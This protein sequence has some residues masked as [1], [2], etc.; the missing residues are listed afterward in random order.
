[1][2]HARD[3]QLRLL[4]VPADANILFLRSRE[5]DVNDEVLRRV[6]YVYLRLE[7]FST[8]SLIT[9]LV[10]AE[11]LRLEDVGDGTEWSGVRMELAAA[12]VSSPAAA[13]SSAVS[14]SRTSSVPR[15]RS[16]VVVMMFM[17]TRGKTTRL[18]RSGL[19][20]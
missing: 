17:R 15:S 19:G 18:G 16:V 13:T 6:E 12:V 10:A 3:A 20:I 14:A 9:V 5:G 1:M 2:N 7:I 4:C 8:L 11:Q